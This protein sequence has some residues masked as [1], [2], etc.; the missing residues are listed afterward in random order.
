[1]R[2]WPPTPAPSAAPNP[3]LRPLDDAT[4]W[5]TGHRTRR[6]RPRPTRRVGCHHGPARWPPCCTGPESAIAI[7]L[8]RLEAQGSVMRGHRFS[9]GAREEAWCE[10]HLLARIHRFTIKRLR[11]EVEPV[12]RQDFMRFLFDG[13]TCLHRCAAARSRKRCPDAG[14]AGKIRRPPP[15][16]GK[17]AARPAHRG[18]RPDWLD[19]LSR[20]RRDRPGAASPIRRAAPAVHPARAPVPRRARGHPAAA[21]PAP[22]G[23]HCRTWKGSG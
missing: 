21:P 6:H 17:R 20:A 11:G 12:S 2:F 15:A 22:T 14:P 5:E 23:V 9:P 8:A 7:A 13:G 3:A 18:L 10:R 19:Q 1:M 4:I 16:P